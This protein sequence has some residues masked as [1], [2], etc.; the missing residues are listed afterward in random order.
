[1]SQ[2]KVDVGGAA[3]IEAGACRV[4]AEAGANHNNSVDRAVE[5]ARAA[6]GAGAWA[7]KFQLY[8]A[9]SLTVVDS[10]KYWTDD[11]G[12]ATQF[13]AF[14]RSD[15]LGYSEYREVAEACRAAGIVF[16]ATPF[17][18]QAVEALEDIGA[19]VY[20]VASGDITNKPL[21]EAVATTGK[22]V[23]LSTGASTVAEISE[24]INWLGLDE[25][26]LVLL[27]CTLTYPTPDSD[28]NFARIASFGSEFAPYLIGMSDHTLGVEGGWMTA[29]LGG[30]CIEKHYTLDKKLP[31]VPDHAMSVDADELAG[32]VAACERGATLRGDDWI[33][34]RDSE[35]PAR[36]MARRSI[37]TTRRIVAGHVITE[38]DLAVKRPAR[39]L[40]PA[41]LNDIVGRR[42]VVDLPADATL[43]LAHLAADR[44]RKP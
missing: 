4:I 9:E 43:E 27:V 2:V 39:G 40:P 26:K 34:V 5:M 14:K 33:G 30:V 11:I 32:L 41:L 15:K 1:V 23:F 28:A 6:A 37:V 12:T 17:D 25:T 7:I 19:P 22:P 16:F 18:L 21:L 35:L 36:E 42:T 3:P 10:P 8:K 13:E 31:D 24:A 44:P 29:A 38:A 20:K